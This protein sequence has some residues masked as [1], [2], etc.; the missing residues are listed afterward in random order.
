MVYLTYSK[1]FIELAIKTHVFYDVLGLKKKTQVM[2]RL[3]PPFFSKVSS[4]F[5]QTDDEDEELIKFYSR[6]TDSKMS[7]MKIAK[8]LAQAV[9]ARIT[10]K[11]DMKNYGLMERWVTPIEVHNKKYDDCDGYAV[12]ICHLCR[13]FG[14]QEWEVFVRAGDAIVD[15]GEA[16]G[17]ANVI[18]LDRQTLR[19]YFLEGSF[20]P[21]RAFRNFGRRSV[22]DNGQYGD[23]WWITNDK[24]SYG[25]SSLPW[26]RFMR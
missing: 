24:G 13:L 16:F 19:F 14:L 1:K 3:K 6:Y 5:K 9:N 26:L 11:T 21:D 4:V 18:V 20:Y 23:T 15:N 25:R 17:H 8:V 22:I 7:N 10:Y 2:W 12:L